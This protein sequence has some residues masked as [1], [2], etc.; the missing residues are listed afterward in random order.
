MGILLILE[1]VELKT[2]FRLNLKEFEFEK[3]S[4]S[5]SISILLHFPVF[6]VAQRKTFSI[7]NGSSAVSS[8]TGRSA[9][10]FGCPH[11]ATRLVPIS[12]LPPRKGWRS[13]FFFLLL[14]RYP[15]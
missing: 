11:P 4:L 2:Y 12:A 14:H 9:F 8:P 10:Q 5:Q 13:A 15:P 7:P 6:V 3:S 1:L